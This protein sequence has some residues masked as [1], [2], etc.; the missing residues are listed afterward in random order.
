MPFNRTIFNGEGRKI[1]V[2]MNFLISLAAI[3]ILA[4]VSWSVLR[5]SEI[6]TVFAEKTYVDKVTT[7][8]SNRMDRDT[9]TINMRIDKEV[10]NLSKDIIDNSAVLCEKISNVSNEIKNVKE[11]VRLNKDILSD[12][13][14]VIHKD[15]KKKRTEQ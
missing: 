10:A 3:V 7:K 4:V 6:P 2:S 8:L 11:Q 9:D 5:V 13:L 1:T 14:D 12:K 15:I